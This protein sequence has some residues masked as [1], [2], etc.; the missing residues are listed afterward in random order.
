MRGWAVAA[1]ALAALAVAATASAEGNTTLS[2][3]DPAGD[4]TVYNAATPL[5]T[6][7]AGGCTN[8]LPPAS[9]GAG[10]PA[11]PTL[12]ILELRFGET[13]RHV[14]VELVL[15]ELDASFPDAEWG[16][17]RTAIVHRVCWAPENGV[18]CLEILRLAVARGSEGT[19]LVESTFSSTD[20][21]CNTRGVCRWGVPYELVEGTPGII[22]WNL[23]RGLAPRP[24]EAGA[25][26]RFPEAQITF[27]SS[28]TGAGA[29]LH[30]DAGAISPRAFS[31]T[32]STE[33]GAPPVLATPLEAVPAG[34][35]APFGN[36]LGATFAT[37][38]DEE[39]DVLRTLVVETPDE[40]TFAVEMRTLA[41]TPSPHDVSVIFAFQGA[42]YH[43]ALVTAE[44]GKRTL[45]TYACAASESTS[46]DTRADV[47]GGF[48]TAP[49]SPGWLNLT[50]PRDA[51]GRPG[52]ADQ[53]SLLA[54]GA[55]AYAPQ[56]APGAPRRLIA[57]DSG[58]AAEPFR[59]RLDTGATLEAGGGYVWPDPL[60]DAAPG[61]VDLS[62][63]GARVANGSVVFTVEHAGELAPPPGA[64][65]AIAVA[66][67]QGGRATALTLVR[68]AA[69]DTV[70]CGDDALALA[71]TPADPRGRGVPARATFEEGRVHFIAPAGCFGAGEV[72][73]ER[74]AAAAF[75]LAGDGLTRLDGVEAGMP[76]VLQGVAAAPVGGLG[77]LPWVLGS[78]G[79]L[80]LVAGA[81]AVARRRSPSPV[82]LPALPTPGEAFLGKYLVERE[83][84]RGSFGT[85]WA[86]RHLALDRPVVLKQLQ[87][88]WSADPEALRRFRREAR[89]LAE[90]DH[91][92]VTRIHDVEEIG[93]TA[94]LV[95][96]F[97]DGGSAADIR[98]LPMPLARVVDLAAQTLEGLAHV[99]AKGVVHHDLKPANL[100]L[101]RSG[102]VKIADFGV[103]A[104]ATSAAPAG[105]VALG[106]GAVLGTPGF[107]AP[108]RLR[109]EPGDA[110][111]DLYAVGVLAHELA[112]GRSP[113]RGE[114]GSARLAALAGEAD[115]AE[116]VLG[117]R[118]AAWVRRAVASDPDD[119]FPDARAMREA[120]LTAAT[121]GVA[122]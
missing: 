82:L 85:V 98:P 28:Q 33:K 83:V 44:G 27:E 20:G 117:D 2:V 64:D 122:R 29:G 118:L 26:L 119:R 10:V 102:V 48:S 21:A 71:P 16:E 55:F 40:L 97:V 18:G 81:A 11:P 7:C 34:P 41:A 94:F 120:L 66:L 92:N 15:A 52:R 116:D 36:G 50:F 106:S 76:V 121:P 17:Q 46:C 78:V 45:A 57:F 49:G 24:L 77:R 8:Q 58:G 89:I 110:R 3:A 23:P 95:M 31:V 5:D 75:L 60:G 74:L 113:F 54:V 56:D 32:D 65:V 47:A 61:G 108:E 79:L 12:D 53:S 91:P 73:G 96:E 99:H 80:A 14:V 22:R 109:G 100:L 105:T 1:V 25:E 107:A 115:V 59:L 4:A 51:L 42:A 90:L 84:G 93:G 6:W 63:V 72:R 70:T 114:P 112:T 35:P 101:T 30:T 104:Y 62:A 9:R 37:A 43:Q 103:A 13:P 86:A 67:Q 88:G 111:S 39:I 69:G 87:L 68:S 19:V 38:T